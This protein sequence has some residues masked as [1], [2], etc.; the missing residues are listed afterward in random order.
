MKIYCRNTKK[1]I[2]GLL[3]DYIFP[4]YSSQQIQSL[5]LTIFIKK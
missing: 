2:D 5:S 4:H 1:I 3:K